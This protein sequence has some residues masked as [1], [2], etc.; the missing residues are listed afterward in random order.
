MSSPGISSEFTTLYLLSDRVSK[1]RIFLFN[2]IA[3]KTL[4]SPWEDLLNQRRKN[5][6]E[7]DE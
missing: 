2:S 4:P 3:A 6:R 7:E 1:I 5:A